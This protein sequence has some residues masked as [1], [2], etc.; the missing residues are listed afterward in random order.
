MSKASK[1]SS[2]GIFHPLRDQQAQSLEQLANGLN[3]S[4]I[5]LVHWAV[6]SCQKPHIRNTLVFVN[7]LGNGW[8]YLAIAILLLVTQGTAS[9]P[10]L[11]AASIA[12]ILSHCIYP[13]IKN[14]L[15]RLRPYDYD[16]SLDLCIKVLDQYSCPSGHVMTATA[17]GIP[18][19]IMLPHLM[20]VIVGGYLLIAWARITLGHHYP[21][22]LLFGAFI[23]GLISTPVS[24]LVI[25]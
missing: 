4:E 8:L 12:A 9:W 19:L 7:H 11:V 21:S 2:N 3:A 18:L 17:V 20:P 13:V 15:A 22:D 5:G 10:L 24:L 14:A 1:D 6:K 16:P 25:S 23:G